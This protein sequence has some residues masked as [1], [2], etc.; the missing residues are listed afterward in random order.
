MEIYLKKLFISIFFLVFRHD[1]IRYVDFTHIAAS[2]T[3]LIRSRIEYLMQTYH[4]LVL[5]L[6]SKLMKNLA[7]MADF[8]TSK[9][10]FAI[11]AY[12]FA[13]PCRPTLLLEQPRTVNCGQQVW[14]QQWTTAVWWITKARTCRYHKTL[15]RSRRPVSETRPVFGTRLLSV[16]AQ[17]PF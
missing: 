15:D 16:L 3:S 11:V 7:L 6:L 8:N 2:K 5:I 14:E 12:F 17:V 1:F 4:I 10:W 9:W 13:P